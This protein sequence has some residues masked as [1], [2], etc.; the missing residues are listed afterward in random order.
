MSSSK[1]HRGLKSKNLINPNGLYT[2]KHKQMWPIKNITLIHRYVISAKWSQ[3]VAYGVRLY[4]MLKQTQY[5]VGTLGPVLGRLPQCFLQY[6]MQEETVW[7]IN[8]SFSLSDS[9]SLV[10][11]SRTLLA[12]AKIFST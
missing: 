1:C 11:A 10:A 3:S 8:G 6:F 4:L 12:H 7:P 2:V 5:Q 9:S